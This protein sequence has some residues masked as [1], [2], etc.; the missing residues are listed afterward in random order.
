MAPVETEDAVALDISLVGARHI[1][2]A[3][4]VSDGPSE[5]Q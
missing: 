4:I 2:A 3:A 5:L 1:A